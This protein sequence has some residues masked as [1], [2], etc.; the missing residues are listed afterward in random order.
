MALREAATPATHPGLAAQAGHSGTKRR[1]LP[2]GLT[3]LFFLAMMGVGRG[4]GRFAAA[5]FLAAIFY[6]PFLR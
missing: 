3:L 4:G 2:L 6:F 5:F 1:N